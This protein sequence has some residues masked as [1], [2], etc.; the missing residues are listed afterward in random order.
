MKIGNTKSTLT[1]KSQ[2]T[3]PKMVR[4]AI[5]VKPGDQVHFVLDDGDKRVYLA[6]APSLADK[7]YGAGRKYA[8]NKKF[9]GDEVAYALE[10]E[11]KEVARE[12]LD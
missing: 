8:K 6:P 3:I 9:Q 7:F 11:A 12:G 1:R 5:G 2:V 10:Q 4:E